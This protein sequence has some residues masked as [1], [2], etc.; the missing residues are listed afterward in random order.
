MIVKFIKENSLMVMIAAVIIIILVTAIMKNK[1]YENEDT[2]NMDKWYP[3][4]GWGKNP[5]LTCRKNKKY[6]YNNE[7]KFLP[8]PT[9][10]IFDLHKPN[11]H[12]V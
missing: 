1:D 8:I 11:E 10:P 5:F 7:C 6:P 9:E 4:N 12:S 3:Y 2:K